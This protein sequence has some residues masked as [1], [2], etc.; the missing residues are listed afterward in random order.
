MFLPI[1]Q[2]DKDPT[3][4]LNKLDLQTTIVIAVDPTSQNDNATTDNIYAH[5]KATY[6]YN[7]SAKVDP[8]QKGNNFTKPAN[9]TFTCESNIPTQ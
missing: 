8:K 9:S 5:L 3:R 7:S 4:Q 1:R 6:D 2:H